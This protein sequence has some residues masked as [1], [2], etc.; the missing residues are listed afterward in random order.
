M[1][2][3]INF[4]TKR[5]DHQNVIVPDQIFDVALGLMKNHR[6]YLVPPIFLVH[7]RD[8]ADGAILKRT[9]ARRDLWGDKS[10]LWIC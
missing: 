7:T 1:F 3:Q 8:P 9:A 2:R 4:I 6:R 10:W 5:T